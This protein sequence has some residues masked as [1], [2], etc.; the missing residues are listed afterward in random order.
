MPEQNEV[1]EQGIKTPVRYD[2]KSHHIFEAD[3]HSLC[4]LSR[5][6]H[7]PRWDK[8][9]EDGEYLAAALN[10]SSRVQAL[11]D[12]LE[13]YATPRK[14]GLNDLIPCHQWEEQN[15][16]HDFPRLKCSACGATDDEPN[17]DR[18]SITA[19]DALAAFTA[20]TG[21]ERQQ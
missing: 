5:N 20:L 17:E 3:G 9:D 1:S 21:K 2:A 14:L 19:I 11:V 13:H 18:C 12:A 4:W 16:G 7:H 15:R 8:K 10:D 6:T